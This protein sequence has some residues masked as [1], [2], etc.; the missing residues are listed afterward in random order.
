MSE[1]RS[2]LAAVAISFILFFSGPWINFNHKPTD[3]TLEMTAS[4]IEA[5]V[6][7]TP[8]YD[9]GMRMRS[10][11]VLLTDPKV[12]GNSQAERVLEDYLEKFPENEKAL[13]L[14]IYSSFMQ[15]KYNKAYEL[16]EKFLS[17]EPFEGKRILQTAH[18]AVLSGNFQEGLD[19]L[20]R[21]RGADTLFPVVVG[22]KAQA[23]YGLGNI[24]IAEEQYRQSYVSGNKDWYFLRSYAGFVEKAGMSA[25]AKEA[26]EKADSLEAVE[27]RFK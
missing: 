13:H 4:I 1:N 12:A 6:H 20:S 14:L 2:T 26:L 24:E 16:A 21:I 5:D 11:A 3:E 19:Y 17:L 7:H 23:N 25:M 9:E 27:K 15:K 10:W 18:L 8:E 22:V